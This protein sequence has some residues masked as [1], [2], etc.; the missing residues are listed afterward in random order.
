M[1]WSA[2]T[3]G[4]RSHTV[5]CH[6]RGEAVVPAFSRREHA[7]YAFRIRGDDRPGP[8]RRGEDLEDCILVDQTDGLRFLA[9]LLAEHLHDLLMRGAARRAGNIPR[10]CGKRSQDEEKSGGGAGL[11]AS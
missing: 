7:A 6:R 10:A 2:G 1:A 4:V 9:E 3:T 11:K 8:G 5:V